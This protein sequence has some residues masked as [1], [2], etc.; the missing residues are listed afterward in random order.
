MVQSRTKKKKEAQGTDVLCSAALSF[1]FLH[2]IFF[3]QIQEENVE[4]F[5]KS[6]FMC[7]HVEFRLHFFSPPSND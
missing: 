2:S 1:S 7:G 3:L 5:E 4:Q 6:S